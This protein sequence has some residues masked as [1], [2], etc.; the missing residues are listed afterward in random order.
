[1]K[2]AAKYGI[3]AAIVVVVLVGV[4][5]FLFL[6]DD[7]PDEV[8]LEAATES[9]SGS[10]TTEG[11]G[12]TSAA[13][14]GGVSGTWTVDTETG[15]FDFESASGTF[16]GIRIQEEL[17]SIG[18]T[19]AVG[20]TGDVDGTVE[21][22]GTTVSSADIEVDMTTITTNES[23][24]DNKVQEALET[25]EFPTATFS[26]TE[27]IDLGAQA[28]EGEPVSVTATGELTIHGVTQQVEIPLEARL[29]DG[30]IVIV[31]S[32]EIAFSDY[33][34]EVPSAPVVQITPTEPTTGEA[35]SATITTASTVAADSRNSVLLT[36]TPSR[37]AAE[38][39]VRSRWAGELVMESSRPRVQQWW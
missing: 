5:A 8:S 13:P 4:G 20:R 23:R 11:G 26:L 36:I 3:I 16:A 17:A 2:P 7:S 33:D 25:G 14:D 12:D 1:M 21:I 24:R 9:L 10:S 15:D 30:T 32:V 38:R 37:V 19:T 29:V 31:G 28:A 6:R 39:L 35:L 18:S 22:D 34:V 27:P